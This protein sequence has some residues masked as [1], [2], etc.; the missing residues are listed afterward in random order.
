[1]NSDNKKT[2]R[3]TSL[4]IFCIFGFGISIIYHLILLNSGSNFLAEKLTSP[5]Y[6]NIEINSEFAPNI[7]I[8]KHQRLEEILFPVADGSLKLGKSILYSEIT[9]F[10]HGISLRARKDLI[11]ETL[12]AIDSVSVFI[13]NRLFYFSRSDIINLPGREI[14]D[15][16]IY[17][18]PDLQYEKTFFSSFFNFNNFVNYYGD[19]NAA[20]RLFTLFFIRPDKFIMAWLFLIFILVLLRENITRFYCYLKQNMKISELALLIFIVFLG[21]AFR[22]NGYVRY[23]SWGDE[24][25]VVSTL[26]NPELPFIVVFNDP[27]NPPFYNILLRIWFIVF[28]WTE[29]SGR[30][31]SVII[32]S[33][34]IIPFYFLVKR[35]SGRKAALLAAL[36]MS[37]SGFLTGW[38]QQTRGYI[39]Q[40]FLVPI[41][42][43][44]FDNIV[45]NSRLKFSNIVCYIIPSVFLVNTH[46]FGSLFIFANFLFFIVYRIIEKSFSWKTS[47]YFFLSNIVIACS[48]LPFFI[49]TAFNNALFNSE[50]NIWIGKPGPRLI[51]LAFIMILFLAVYLYSRKSFITKNL[52]ISERYFYDYIIFIST[53]LFLT[54]FFVSAIIR[55]ILHPKYLVILFP[56]QIAF[57]SCLFSRA[58]SSG[59]K[60]IAIVGSIFLFAWIL[61]GYEANG[62][63]KSAPF[64]EN[65]TFIEKDASA[66]PE[67]ISKQI[68]FITKEITHPALQRLAGFYG[69]AYLP[70]YSSGD[71]YDILYINYPNGELYEGNDQDKMLRIRVNSKDN[72]YKIYS[73]NF[74]RKRNIK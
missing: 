33:A 14:N 41:V 58:L 43:I 16:V 21:F 34:A 69:Q 50:F 36:F 65:L 5:I 10:I 12:N 63:S 73:D 49:V 45:K 64:H 44:C 42:A 57:F 60:I 35:F 39:L 17:E 24:L 62:G 26:A 20:T 51:S 11:L 1:M 48:L 31:F 70:E 27:G 28:G 67:K 13:G 18:L 30:L 53:V 55:P 8:V 46:Y 3:E 68:V 4:I 72:V 2:W 15:F 22:I 74:L 38:S 56:F 32:G 61:G 71:E 25:D 37:A 23:S 9:G 29:Q 47:V 52:L 6:L 40:I 7:S 66:S 19:L 59:K 54:A